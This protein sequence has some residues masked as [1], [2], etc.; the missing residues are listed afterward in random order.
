MTRDEAW[1][2]LKEIGLGLAEDADNLTWALVALFR[3]ATEAGSVTADEVKAAAL[4]AGV[5]EGRFDRDD[6]DDEAAIW[7]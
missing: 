7:W 6:E 5:T 4:E 1:D 2:E 3:R